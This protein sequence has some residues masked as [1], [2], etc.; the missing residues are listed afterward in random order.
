MAMEFYIVNSDLDIIGIIDTYK[1]A[2]WTE[3]YYTSGDFELY[4]P[5]TKEMINR[6][7]KHQFIVRMDDP[8]KAMIVESIKLS[9]S[10]DNGNYLTVTGRSLS[11]I[12]SR[13]IVWKQTTYNGY[14][15]KAARKIVTDSFIN[16]EIADRAVSQMVLGDELGLTY[17]VKVQ[18]TGDVVE[19]AIQSLCVANKLGYDLK[20]DLENKCFSFVLYE[21]KDRSY[22][23]STNPYVVFSNDFENLLSS[24]YSNDDTRY[25]N[26]AQVAGEGQG[27]NRKK[28]VVGTASGLER[29]EVFVDARNQSTNDGEIDDATYL[30]LLSQEGVAKLAELGTTESIDSEVAPNHTYVL[31]EDYFLGDVVEVINEYGIAMTPRVVE[32]IECQNDTGYTCIPTFATDDE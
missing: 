11:S 21:G 12:L 16:P 2:I 5:A 4:I 1:S 27:I 31:N 23:Q 8:T 24:D 9:T 7:K 26:V 29:Y 20:M 22:N 19:Q 32:V 28:A 14:L 18:F 13:R 3:R 6:I 17:T 10:A 25:K 15:E 30:S